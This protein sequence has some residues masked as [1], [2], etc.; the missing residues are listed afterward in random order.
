MTVLSEQFQQLLN[1][2][3]CL[4]WCV[5]G[6]YQC[7]DPKGIW[8]SDNALNLTGLGIYL[9]IFRNVSLKPIGHFSPAVHVALG[10]LFSFQI[11]SPVE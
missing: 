11:I 6:I 4:E 3:L 8:P 5:L 2:E 7:L 10:A 9:D 1:T